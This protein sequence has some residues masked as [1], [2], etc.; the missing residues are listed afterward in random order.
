MVDIDKLNSV[1]NELDSNSKDIAKLSDMIK[2]TAGILDKVQNNTV[3]LED[4]LRTVETTN[5]RNIVTTQLCEK[6]SKTL[7]DHC[8]QS[9]ELN[10]I[11]MSKVN[12]LLLEMKNENANI[13]RNFESAIN[14]KFDYM[15]SDIIVENRKNVDEILS[16]LG[17]KIESTKIDIKQDIQDRVNKLNDTFI[18]KIKFTNILLLGSVLLSLLGILLP[19]LK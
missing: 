2:T 5:N 8:M 6:A 17:E 14:T 7:D 4:L 19:F 15:K 10:E 13:F 18:H 9:K 12:T 1:I 16:K 3:I 11:F